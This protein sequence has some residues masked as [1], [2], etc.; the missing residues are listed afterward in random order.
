M[1]EHRP[2][3]LVFGANDTKA[4]EIKFLCQ[5]LEKIGIDTLLVDLDLHAHYRDSDGSGDAKLSAMQKMAQT[6]HAES[7]AHIEAKD[8]DGI[9]AMGGGV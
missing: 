2:C 1:A 7:L 5:C 3:T 6:A 8:I 4:R 9:I